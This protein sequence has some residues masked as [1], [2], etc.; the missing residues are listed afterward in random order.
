MEY[1]YYKDPKGN[2]G[3]DLNGWLWPL[4]FGKASDMGKDVLFYGIGSILSK[5]TNLVDINTHLT[6]IIFGTGVR[7]G[8]EPIKTDKNWDI[9]FVRGPLSSMALGGNVKYITDAAYCIRSMEAFPT[10]LNAKKIHEISVMP[11][12]SSISKFDWQSICEK[13]GV[14]YISPHSESGVEQTIKDIAS[15]KYVIS[16]A[17]HG[18]IVADLLRVPW[19]RFVLSTPTGEG[20]VISEF[21]WMDW[22]F[23]I[24]IPAIQTAHINLYRKT[25]LNKLIMRGTCGI[26]NAEF[27]FK[28][29]VERDILEKLSVVKK[30]DFYLSRDRVVYD[31]DRRIKEKIHEL[32]CEIF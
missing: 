8:F 1:I 29:K 4:I 22:L 23:S 20:S 31:I 6:K 5:S 2:F 9:K 11:H 32:K 7:P 21:K 14:N 18:A 27:F 12:I 30:S 15:S 17:M 3:D 24:K 16:E 25:Y 26:V 19:N 13:L 28:N 10:F